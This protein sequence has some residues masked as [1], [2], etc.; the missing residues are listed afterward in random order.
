MQN[1][2]TSMDSVG[3]ILFNSP[4]GLRVDANDMD[5]ESIELILS[6]LFFLEEWLENIECIYTKKED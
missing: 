6:R 3:N 5:V 4:D 2:L 1:R